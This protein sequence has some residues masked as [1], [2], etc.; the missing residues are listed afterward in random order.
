MS[1]AFDLHERYAHVGVNSSAAIVGEV[2]L[3]P[4]SSL[5]LGSGAGATVPVPAE[6]EVDRLEVVRDGR[7]LL[8]DQL[9]RIH[10]VDDAGAGRVR[11]TPEE[12][13]AGGVA[14]PAPL[15]WA[16]LNLT[17]VPGL[18]VFVLYL[19]LGVSSRPLRMPSPTSEGSG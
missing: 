6:L 14:S 18:S 1:T 17:V 9:A 5:I 15:R 3:P 19:P 12:L 11:G 10:V 8:F 13:R 2:I 4:G 16:R 7:W